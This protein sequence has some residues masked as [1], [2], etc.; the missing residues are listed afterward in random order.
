MTCGRAAYLIGIGTLLAAFAVSG[1][2][3][4]PPKH[5]VKGKITFKGQPMK[6]QP[7]VGK[8]LVKFLEQDVPP[9]VDANY[10]KVD[11]DGSFEVRGD[12]NGI[13]AGRYKICVEWFEAFGKTPDKLNG[14][15]D[16]KSSIIFK[17]VPDDGFLE[18]DVSKPGG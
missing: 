7:Q 15:F 11:D 12:G 16:E 6:V 1:C 4:G 9:P 2:S 10:A 17:K 13:V 14:R 18:I 3:S 5:I 8:V